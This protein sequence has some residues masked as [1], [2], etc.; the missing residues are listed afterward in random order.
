LSNVAADLGELVIRDLFVPSVTPFGGDGGID[1]PALTAH[2]EWLIAAGA[3]G[4][5]L[6]GT[7]GEGPSITVSEKVAT[8]KAL[9][10][11]LPGVPVIASVTENALPDI[12]EA[13]KGFNKL[14]LAGTLVLPPSYF[15]EAEP[16]GIRALFQSVATICEHPVL[17]YHI[18][19]LAPA[20]PV[21]IVADLPL[22]GAKDSGGDITYTDAVLK[23]GKSV[24]VG[25]EA[26]VA[27][28]IEHGAAG[29]ICGMG[30]VA[31]ALMADVCRA[32]RAGRLA[33]AQRSL[34]IVLRLQSAIIE[35]APGMEWVAAFKQ[36][37]SALHGHDLAGVRTPLR[38][39]RDYLS[40][41]VRDSL[42]EVSS[43]TAA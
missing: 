20:V 32:A 23:T 41:S 27:T 8:A 22:W 4:I 11:A 12:V 40:A 17:A 33:D 28:S 15:R 26:L 42:D 43:F 24:M 3:T 36:V 2:C 21:S 13:V 35:A 6:F 25:A 31:P 18:P 1:V 37:A 10:A 38:A 5:M 39:R 9:T 34:D 16:D 30:N 14:P 7:T 19:S 29:T